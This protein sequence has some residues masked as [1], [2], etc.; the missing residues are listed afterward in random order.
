MTDREENIEIVNA[1]YNEEIDIAK[2]FVINIDENK[3]N[4][5][6]LS[7]KDFDSFVNQL[8]SGSYSFTKDQRQKLMPSIIGKKF[9]NKVNVDLKSLN[10][11][12]YK[13]G[14]R[15]DSFHNV[16]DKY[17]FGQVSFEERRKE[18]EE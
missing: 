17:P 18:L 4:V 10:K 9:K 12:D 2:L 14:E 6:V 5:W 7:G 8:I 11:D 13:D 3:E 15:L 1:I 16:F